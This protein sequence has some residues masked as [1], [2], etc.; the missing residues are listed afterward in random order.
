MG[1]SLI[2]ISGRNASLIN[3]KLWHVILIA[4]VYIFISMRYSYA[5][6][7]KEAMI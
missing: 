5:F 3:K 7:F 6:K 4:G 1:D 2:H